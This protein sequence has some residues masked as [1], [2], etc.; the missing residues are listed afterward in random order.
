MI[1]HDIR[2]AL[3]AMPVS[4]DPKFSVATKELYEPLLAHA[5]EG[6]SATRDIA[7]GPHQRHKLDVFHVAGTKPSAIL[8][9][10]PG[11][12]FSGGDKRSFGHLGCYFA[13][14]G[15]LGITMNYRLSPEIAWPAGAQDV[16]TAVAWAKANAATYGADA[17]RVIV[18]GHSAGASHCA[19]Y[20]FDPEIRGDAQVAGAI[21]VSGAAYALPSDMALTAPNIQAYFGTD[22]TQITRRSAVSHVAGTK[23]PVMLAVAE[24]DPGVL[25]TPTLALAAALSIRDDRC[26]PLYRLEGHNHFSPPCSFGTSDDELGGAAIRF[27]RDLRPV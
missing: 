7:Y 4:L 23:V 18:F 9:Y 5:D 10:I 22:N 6:V 1:Q 19:T 13:R 26:P 24:L 8:I 15:V 3:A 20:L 27:I 21:L 25:V 17:S 14:R 16:A 11:G 12:G 2:H